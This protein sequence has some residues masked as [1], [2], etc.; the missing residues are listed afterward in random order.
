M[1]QEDAMAAIKAMGELDQ[2]AKSEKLRIA[3]DRP[4]RQ[5]APEGHENKH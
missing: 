1:R 5:A 4:P 2:K 3:A